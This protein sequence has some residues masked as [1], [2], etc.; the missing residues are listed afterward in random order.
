MGSRDHPQGPRPFGETPAVLS[1]LY[2]INS[3]PAG[4]VLI[5]TVFV[6][7]VLTADPADEPTAASVLSPGI[8]LSSSRRISLNISQST[9]TLTSVSSAIIVSGGDSWSSRK[10]NGLEQATNL[11]DEH[12]VEVLAT[13][14]CSIPR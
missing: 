8:S 2:E 11:S 13:H 1:L 10:R 5:D 9:C 12:E 14:A 3:P 7:D 6:L 4:G